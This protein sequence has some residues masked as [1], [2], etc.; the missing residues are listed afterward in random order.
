[1][2][3]L[4]T[5]NC[6]SIHHFI[7]YAFARIDDLSWGTKGSDKADSSKIDGSRSINI[8]IEYKK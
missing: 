7:I 8:E 5:V 6:Y 2:L 3:W 4:T 1:M